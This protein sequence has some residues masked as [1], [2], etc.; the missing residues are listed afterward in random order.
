SLRGAPSAPLG[1]GRRGAARRALTRRLRDVPELLS[2]GEGAK[3]FQRL[4][5]DLPDA[6]A[7]DAE[8]AADLVERARCLAVQPE[9]HLEHAAFALA[10]HLE[11]AG[12]RLVPQ[13][14]RR[15]LVGKGLRLGLDEVPELRLLVVA[16]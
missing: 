4:I 8:R 14:Q 7:G 3:L 2:L 9:A 10:E 5:L 12:E 11:G 6:L 16:D 1:Q 15:L 13:R